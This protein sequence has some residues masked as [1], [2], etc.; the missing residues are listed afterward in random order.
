[1]DT[2][3]QPWMWA[4]FGGFVVVAVFIDL[5]MLRSQGAHK[6][7]AKE[8]LAW[9]AVWVALALVF[10]GVLYFWLAGTHGPEF[11]SLKA[12]EFLTGYLI[13]KSLS[14]DNIFVFLMIFTFF[15]VA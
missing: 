8:A 10:C 1:M 13:E 15:G 6:V 14:V 4:A 12:T 9:S 7:S 3:A 2:L 5:V 11:A